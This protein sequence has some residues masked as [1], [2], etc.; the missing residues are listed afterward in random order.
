M[1]KI[2]EN[3]LLVT[4]PNLLKQ[5]Y[6]STY[7]NRLRH[8]TMKTEFDDIFCLKMELWESRLTMLNW[9]MKNL[10][11][12]LKKL[13]NNKTMDPHGMINEIFKEGTI[14]FDLKCALLY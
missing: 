7:V 11:D 8:R 6:L 4:V 3:G 5:L 14:G 12:V 13:K 9:T 2:D 10:E 1:A